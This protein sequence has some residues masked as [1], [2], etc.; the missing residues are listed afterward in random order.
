MTK[1]MAHFVADKGRNLVNNP[2]LINTSRSQTNNN[3]NVNN[4]SRSLSHK[5]YGDKTQ[6]ESVRERFW[7]QLVQVY[8][9]IPI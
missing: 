3:T 9:F 6:F 4:I 1:K 8:H 7:N 2:I 5:V